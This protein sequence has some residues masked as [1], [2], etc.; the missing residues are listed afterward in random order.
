MISTL[1]IARAKLGEM[2]QSL[3]ENDVAL[4]ILEALIVKR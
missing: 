1:L 3:Q 2:R 4:E